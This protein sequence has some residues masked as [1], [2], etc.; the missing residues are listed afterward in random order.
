MVRVGCDKERGR[1]TCALT[2]PLSLSGCSIS[3]LMKSLILSTDCVK[4]DLGSDVNA[5]GSRS[6]P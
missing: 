1:N 5:R 2:L 4:V 6:V 3:A